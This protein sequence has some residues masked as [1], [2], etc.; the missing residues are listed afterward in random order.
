MLIDCDSCAVKDLQCGD[1]VMSVLLGHEPGA[2]E[3]DDREVQALAALAAGGLV[4]HLQLVPRPEDEIRHAPQ[5]LS[6][7]RAL[8]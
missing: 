2:Y 4:P 8:P 5:H 1:C 7:R 6:A 3:A